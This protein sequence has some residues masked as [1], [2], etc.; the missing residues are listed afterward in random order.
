MNILEHHYMSCYWKVD[1]DFLDYVEDSMSHNSVIG[2]TTSTRSH[3][4]ISC[5]SKISYPSALSNDTRTSNVSEK[6]NLL[7]F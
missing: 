6:A 7:D 2:L 1:N 5:A 4:K 3:K